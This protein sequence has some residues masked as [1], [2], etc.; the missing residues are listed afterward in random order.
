MPSCLPAEPGPCATV[1]APLESVSAVLPEILGT[2]GPVPG[3]DFVPTS[4]APSLLACPKGSNRY[5]AAGQARMRVRGWALRERV[6]QLHCFEGKT[7]KETARLLGRSYKRVTGVWAAV[8]RDVSGGNAT[9]EAHREAVRTYLD[10]HYRKIMEG[11][12]GL[13]G[14][15][16]AYGAVVV[17]AGKALAELHG[18]K[19]ED[20]LPTGFTLEDVGREV[21]VVSPLLI[22]RLDQVR[23][24]QGV[25]A[26]PASGHAVRW[27]KVR[28][29]R[30]APIE[31]EPVSPVAPVV[32]AA[33]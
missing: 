3:V 11:A 19:P 28:E 14:E 16:A 12:Q 7:L 33:E 27:A 20:V 17:A 26:D 29:V 1:V 9:P 24:L 2:R 10:R 18:I 8:A 21:R 32:D 15:A 22:D 23:A 25:G 4:A 13:L 31:G 30:S 6:V 5:L